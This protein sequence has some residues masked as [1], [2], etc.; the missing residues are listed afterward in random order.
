[1]KTPQV[2]I[3]KE[4]YPFIFI[5][6]FI[7]L[8]FALS[9]FTIGAY[10]GI[11]LTTFILCFFRDPERFTPEKSHIVV[12]PADG[13][14]IAVSTIQDD[15]YLHNEVIKVSIFMNIFN[16]HVNRVPISGKVE[17]VAYT[18]G[19]FYAADSKMG[20][21]LNEKC[22]T[23]V[24]TEF[25]KKIVFIQ[26]AGLVARRIVNWLQLDEKVSKG[27]RFGLIRFGSRVDVYLPVDTAVAVE[28][29]D[30]VRA[31]ESALAYLSY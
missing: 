2:P 9:G 3:A 24:D 5:S 22:A 1:M 21:L 11:A 10:V 7:T 16:V 27:D 29:G 31:G 4:G 14:V 18:P 25:D 19:K 17:R 13:K 6:A 12:S 30:K 15:Q 26:V 28:V 20:L 23:I 8:I